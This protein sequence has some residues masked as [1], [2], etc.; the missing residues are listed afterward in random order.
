[1]Q[2][3]SSVEKV[4]LDPRTADIVIES[5]RKGEVPQEGLEHF[6]TGIDAHVQALMAELPRIADARGRI[7]FVRGE[8]GAGKTFFLHHLAALARRDGF[9]TA[10][11]RVAYPG[12]EL[13]KPVEIYRAIVSGLSVQEQSQGALRHILDQWLLKAMEQVMDP[14][15]G[16]GLT[17][18]MPE[19]QKALDEVV[20]R[21]LGPVTDAAP[22][23]AQLV[24]A[25]AEVSLEN[26]YGLARGILQ[27]LGGD[28]QVDATVKRRAHMVGKLDS[29]GVLGMLRGLSTLL[30]QSG[31]RGLVIL[32]DEV[33]RLVRLSRAD[34][35]KTGLEL[36]QNWMGALTSGQLPHTLVVVAGTTSFFASSRG[37]PMLE[38]LLQRI[39][40]VDESEFPDLDAVQ[41]RLPTFNRERLVAVG[42]R[43]RALYE[44]N[45]PGTS[46]RCS[47]LF[48]EQLAGDVIG[49]FR[50]RVETTPRKFLQELIGVLGRIK[51]YPNYLPEKNYQFRI[52]PSDPDL[53]APERAAL[54]GLSPEEAE[55]AQYELPTEIDL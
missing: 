4:S 47:D 40:D 15:L 43:V 25:Y 16:P 20:Q 14:S 33:E 23:F 12:T 35:R 51:L 37:V 36:I 31:Y 2:V 52:N 34:S 21:L 26:D 41:L 29:A 8:Y 11:V 13:H 30:T 5:L 54:E 10:Y 45:H 39:G 24:S 44:S 48:L 17:P 6:A 19:F 32:V 1:M 7:R 27:L 42:R 9:A 49:A 38:P 22:G 3:P 28:P 50:G 53:L 55:Q 46:A 18:D